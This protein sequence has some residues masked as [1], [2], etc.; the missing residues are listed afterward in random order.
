MH[1]FGLR[2]A[3]K[4]FKHISVCNAFGKHYLFF[5]HNMYLFGCIPNASMYLI[6]CWVIYTQASRYDSHTNT[7]PHNQA[8]ECTNWTHVTTRHAQTEVGQG[9]WLFSG[10]MGH[11]IQCGWFFCSFLA[12]LMQR[13]EKLDLWIPAGSSQTLN[14]LS[15]VGMA[16]RSK[17]PWGF[18]SPHGTVLRLVNGAWFSWAAMTDEVCHPSKLWKWY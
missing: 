11:V 6:S 8:S 13:R 2:L 15:I 7:D 5:L 9:Y 18:S 4:L 3:H 14:M 1:T 12:L 17:L 16:E 10:Q